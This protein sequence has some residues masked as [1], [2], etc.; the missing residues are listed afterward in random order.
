VTG[1]EP[2]GPALGT[3]VPSDAPA[4]H[5]AGRVH[6]PAVSRRREIARTVLRNRL[7][8]AG[9]V[10][11][12][13]LVVVAVLGEVIAPYGINELDVANRLTG[14]GT[15]HWFGTDDL[16]RDVFSRVVIATRSSLFVGF[17]A[18]GIALVIGVPVGLV[19][20]FYGGA[21]DSLFMR[22]MDMLF[23]FPAIL[24]ALAILAVRGPGLGTAMIAIGIVYTPIFARITRASTLSVRQ[25]VYVR[26][27]RSIG[28]SDR[29]ILRRHVL[30][31]IAGPIIVQTS[32]SLAFAILSEAA[33]SV[34]GLGVQP[35][36]PAWGRML[37]DA[38]GYI[39][40]APWVGVFPGLA[41]LVTVMAFNFVGDG[42]RDAL[43]P[44]QTSVIESR[45]QTA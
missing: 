15:D 36:E 20:G 21:V 9:L 33:L 40:D 14:P 31:N 13:L 4:G 23:S 3:R 18:V 25:E 29:R 42:L 16:G 39:E 27:A 2:A 19:S 11:L 17:I 8:T 30:P 26:A 24:L 44:R 45:G 43:D 6:A 41:I 32:L 28:A 12:V 7:A 22:L 5:D 38:R 35:P 10:V 34:L 37:A 1:I